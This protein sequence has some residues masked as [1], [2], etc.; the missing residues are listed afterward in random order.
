[1][2]V[3]PVRNYGIRLSFVA[4]FPFFDPCVFCAQAVDLNFVGVEKQDH[5]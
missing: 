4:T 2:S 1:M 5:F 3:E